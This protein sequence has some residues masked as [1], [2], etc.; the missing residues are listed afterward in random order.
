MIG[1]NCIIEEQV[2]I[3]NKCPDDAK[4]GEQTPMV[5]GNYNVL[6]VGTALEALTV[7]DSNVFEAKGTPQRL[8]PPSP[9]PRANHLGA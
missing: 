1:D 3:T 7:G 6:E 5:I 4:T 2:R 9:R 8:C